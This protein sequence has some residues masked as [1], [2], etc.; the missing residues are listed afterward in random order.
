MW[1]NINPQLVN[2]II[3]YILWNNG[4]MLFQISDTFWLTLLT[5]LCTSIKFY[6][7]GYFM[8]HR[9]KHRP[10]TAQNPANVGQAQA[11]V[12]NIHIFYSIIPILP[13]IPTVKTI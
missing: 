7:S 10:K 4:S 13:N 3:L 8:A 11:S 6:I 9:F 5:S 12:S 1:H 2:L